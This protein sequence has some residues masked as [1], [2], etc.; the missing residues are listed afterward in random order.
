MVS[1][2]GLNEVKVV[3]F[4]DFYQVVASNYQGIFYM[5][6]AD[7]IHNY[8]AVYH[9]HAFAVFALIKTNYIQLKGP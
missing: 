6:Y 9:M 5:I 8:C 3:H 1:V 7:C 4:I 2:V